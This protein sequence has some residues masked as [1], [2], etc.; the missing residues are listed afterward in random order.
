MV[1]SGGKEDF[2]SPKFLTQR[3]FLSS[4]DIK[5][6]LQLLHYSAAQRRGHFTHFEATSEGK[7]L[8]SLHPSLSSTPVPPSH[9]TPHPSP[10]LRSIIKI[11]QYR[12]HQPPNAPTPNSVLQNIAPDATTH[13]P[14][15]PRTHTP[16]IFITHLPPSLTS[17]NGKI[18]TR[19][20][21]QAQQRQPPQQNLRPARRRP[22]RAPLRQTA[23]TGREFKTA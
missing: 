11:H 7:I 10:S 18:P 17:K 14:S 21:H 15:A 1:G 13:Y 3:Y 2:Q 22:H 8:P 16:P 20:L 12:N 23:G 6:K 9:L 4:R 19:L 5:K